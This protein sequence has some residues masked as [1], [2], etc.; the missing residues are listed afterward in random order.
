MA[1]LQTSDELKV[2]VNSIPYKLLPNSSVPPSSLPLF[3]SARIFTSVSKFALRIVSPGKHWIRLYFYPLPHSQCSASSSVFS[4]STDASLLLHEFSMKE[5]SSP[6]LKEYLIDVPS[7]HLTITF[8][9]KTSCAFLNALEVVSAPT[10]LISD[11]ASEIP[12]GGVFAGLSKFA[13]QVSHRLNIGGPIITPDNDTLSRTFPE[14]GG[15]TPYI[16]PRSVYATAEQMGDSET[17]IQ[18]FN[19]TWKIPG[20]ILVQ[21]GPDTEMQPGQ[22]NAILNGLEVIKMSRWDGSLDGVVGV[23][24]LIGKDVAWK[25]IAGIG[26]GIAVTGL[27]ILGFIMLRWKKR[28]QGWEKNQSFSFWLLPLHRSSQFSTSKSSRSTHLSS[29]RLG[30]F[31]SF[32]EL[33]TATQNFEETA[34]LGVGGF[35]K[36]YL[37]VMEDGTKVAIKRGIPG[38]AQG[39]NEFQ[40][41]IQLLSKLRHRHLVSL[42]GFTD[43]KSEMILVYEYMS[44]GPLRDHLYGKTKQGTLSWKQR[45][46]ICIGSARGLHYL[47]TGSSEA[48]IHRDVKT[49]NILLDENLVAKVADFGL[50]KAAPM[51]RSPVS[52][53]VKGS[54]G[55]LDPEYFRLQQLTDKSDVYSF[56]VLLFEVLCARPVLD[57][58]LPREQVNLGEWAMSCYKRGTLDKIIDPEIKGTIDKESLKKF[59]EAAE[60]CLAEYGVDRPAMGDVLWNLEYAL[61]LQNASVKISEENSIGSVREK[62]DDSQVIVG[63]STIISNFGDVEGR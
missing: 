57:P 15:A 6:E 7:D 20:S 61:Q 10:G 4:V 26:M 1:Y 63:T 45:L 14:S 58:T 54:F 53:A 30:K 36:V 23:A 35:G 16:A 8:T 48:I 60:K 11:E 24:G 40:T 62:D 19:L 34:I 17:E 32:S 50:S 52:T 56:G 5:N 28:P 2:T 29:S 39:I 47:H 31:F 38:S 59:V 37:G 25:I 51:D 33:Q 43:E 12:A 22:M 49:T 46:E 42:I 13:L 9:P 41:E 44:N 18:N 21:V 55:Y 27:L 3:R